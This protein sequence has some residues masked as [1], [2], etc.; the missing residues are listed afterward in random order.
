MIIHTTFSAR[1]SS[2]VRETCTN[3]IDG[4]QRLTSLTLLLIY[5]HHLQQGRD[6]AVDVQPLIFSAQYGQKSFNLDVE[7]RQPLMKALFDADALPAAGRAWLGGDDVGALP[8][9]RVDLP[10]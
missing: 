7:E 10:R 4:Q 9:H 3:L 1:S 2:H 6:D 8:R 5:L